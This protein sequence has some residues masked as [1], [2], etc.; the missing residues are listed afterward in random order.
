MIFFASDVHLASD[1][2]AITARVLSFLERAR[3]E[4]SAVYLLGDIFEA[5]VGDED[6]KRRAYQPVFTAL[7]ELTQAGVTVC[8]MAGN[9]DF[10]LSDQVL[11]KLGM[12]RLTDP[13]VLSLP[14][15][16]FVLSHGDLYCT[17]DVAYQRY[18]ATVHNPET[19]AKFLRL[20]YW[21]RR[22]FARWLR[23][24]S[25]GRRTNNRTQMITDVDL[26]TVEDEA[27]RYG[28][29]TLIHGHTHRPATHDLIV[30]GIHVERWVLADWSSE[31]GEFLAWDEH[32]EAEDARLTRHTI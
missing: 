27:R 21:V 9:R 24:R 28:Y 7:C 25:E 4:A 15:W 1:T 26:A 12:H 18:R 11:A 2:P 16:Q 14:N 8:F 32:A 19:Q 6:L 23:W 13:Y 3:R 30:D 31:R 22:L 29:A 10:L 17:G 5:W 20:P